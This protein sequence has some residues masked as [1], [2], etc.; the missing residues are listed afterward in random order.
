MAVRA[1]A[2]PELAYHRNRFVIIGGHEGIWINYMMVSGSVY[3][4][5]SLISTAGNK[6]ATAIRT[7]RSPLGRI[8]PIGEG[9][10]L[11]MFDIRRPVCRR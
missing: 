9:I 2:M 11:G 10:T 5:V 4:I 8:C 7:M 3:G 1:S 6:G